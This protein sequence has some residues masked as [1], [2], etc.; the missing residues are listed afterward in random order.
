MAN[1]IKGNTYKV[2]CPVCK[3]DTAI[4]THG[5]LRYNFPAD[6][7]TCNNCSQVFIN[8]FP[9]ED[10]IK[11]YYTSEYRTDYGG[12]DLNKRFNNDIPEAQRRLNNILSKK[13]KITS[14]LEIGSGSGAFINLA[15]KEFE[16]VTAIEPD[17]NSLNYIKSK[18][19]NS[20]QS[21]D[22]I[23][24]NQKYDL[25]VL[26]HVLE[27]LVTPVQFLNQLTNHLE[28]KGEIIIEVP[29]IT[30]AL[31]TT[32]NIPEF[33]DFY[34]CSPHLF[35][36][37]EVTLSKLISLTNSLQVNEINFIQRYNLKNHFKWLESRKA[38]I[39]NHNKYNILSTETLKSYEQ[40]L[41]KAK[42]TDTLWLEC[43]LKN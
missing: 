18:E 43:S 11:K 2:N 30:D 16:S 6:I 22:H 39:E 34:F 27:H 36:F 28:S 38:Q 31:I 5:K 29:N 23:P 4:Y 9:Q 13:Q 17:M 19:I 33:K 14:L 7:F 8:P 20:Y 25:I 15:K 21:I 24:N 32:Y 26:F 10:D 42:Q 41:I 37:S 40:D 3:N 1:Y 35:Y 12:L